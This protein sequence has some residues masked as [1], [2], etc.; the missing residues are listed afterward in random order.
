MTGHFLVHAMICVQVFGSS[1]VC[2]VLGLV[3]AEAA[4]REVRFTLLFLA[5]VSR[6]QLFWHR[7]S[8]SASWLVRVLQ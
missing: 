3:N 7:L 2:F 4:H 5:S 6:R 8:R 1:Q